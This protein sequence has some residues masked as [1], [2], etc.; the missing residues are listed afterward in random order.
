MLKLREIYSIEITLNN[1]TYIPQN[2][3]DDVKTYLPEHLNM[4]DFLDHC[5]KPLRRSIRVNTLKL[6]I[7]DFK[8]YCANH[9]WHI[10]AVPWCDT[11]FWLERSEAEENA[12]PLGSTD[13]HL[14]GGIYI[15]EAS[16]MLPPMAL[17]ESL[18]ETSIVLDM[19]SAPGS[20]TSQIAA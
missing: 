6:S 2:F 4:D 20:K 10:E 14:S 9:E 13:I 17:R 1:L 5:Q 16:S 11:G 7:E 18:T 15:Q 12:L 19:A 3:I 8:L